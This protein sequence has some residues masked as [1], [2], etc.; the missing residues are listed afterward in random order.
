[1][2]RTITLSTKER[3][4]DKWLYII[5]AIAVLGAMAYAWWFFNNHHKVQT[6]SYSPTAEVQANRYYTAQALLKDAKTLQGE[7]GRT[8]LMDVFGDTVN[9]KNEMVVI[10]DV[11][12]SYKPHF[13][14]M[15]AWVANG[16]H[17]VVFNKNILSDDIQKTDSDYQEG[18][19]PLMGYL[20]IDYVAH[21]SNAFDDVKKTF[22][23][24]ATPL[25]IDGEMMIVQD[26]NNMSNYGW[27]SAD[28]FFNQYPNAKAINHQIYH[29]DSHALLANLNTNLT[30]EQK[31]KIE[32]SLKQSKNT[33]GQSNL[34][35]PNNALFDVMIDKGRL[36][37]LASDGFFVNPVSRGV[38]NDTPQGMPMPSDWELLTDLDGDKHGVYGYWGGL[39]RADNGELLRTLAGE[40][41][42]YLAPDVESTGFFVL[43]W[44]Y[45]MWS[46]IGMVL[47]VGVCLLALP[48]RFGAKVVY[49][50]DTSRNIFGFFGHVGQ[51]LWTS[52]GA[53]ALFTQNRHAL[54]Q[55]ILAKEHIKEQTETSIAQAV[56]EKTGLSYDMVYEALYGT[57]EQ[58]SDFVRISRSFA[59]LSRFYV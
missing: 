42:T 33:S 40:R 56:S 31:E 12:S 35:H 14:E 50:T 10:Y 15:M 32:H 45:L 16:G 46:V 24:F 59:R 1:M 6:T 49:E 28:E 9:A 34:F 27:F 29:Q 36:T 17:L 55:T 48:K 19:N 52:D 4:Q 13:D 38:D 53:T 3:A 54:I 2:N 39:L 20:G 25:S 8:R 22:N 18:Q 43:L 51:Y 47:T 57:W 23:V 21:D 7:S 41:H 11:T 44:R 37:I 58:E 30:N 26:V 5:I